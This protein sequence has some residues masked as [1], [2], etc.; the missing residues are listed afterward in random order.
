V[1][2]NDQIGLFDV[3][4]ELHAKRGKPSPVDDGRTLAQARQAVLEGRDDGV[5]CPCCDKFAKRERRR[6]YSTMAAGLVA[7]V[8]LWQENGGEWV[9]VKEINA[10]L[11]PYC[12]EGTV[13]PSSDFAKLRH[14]GFVEGRPN[15]D[16]PT[17]RTTGQWRPR[18][19]AVD[20][21]NGR[22]RVPEAYYVYNKEIDA[23]SSE[24]IS[25]GEALAKRFNYSEL[26]GRAA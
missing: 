4:A 23:W 8:R 26:M 16:D 1:S 10:S 3:P 14:W 18:Q 21:V 6:L 2:G 12:G 13:N 19:K 24:Q 11:R 5:Q 7:C 9:D 25:V 22:I 17:K 20:W 15:D